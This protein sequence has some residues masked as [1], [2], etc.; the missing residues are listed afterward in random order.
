MP[1]S[2][3]SMM[4]P[5][6]K[7]RNG[8]RPSLPVPVSAPSSSRAP[9][10]VE[11]ALSMVRGG[12]SIFP[13]EANGKKPAIAGGFKAATKDEGRVKRWFN[14][15]ASL[16]IGIAT[17]EP[18]RFFALDA[19]GDAGRKS[20]RCLEA[21]NGSLP[22]TVTV[23]TPH[24]NHFYFRYPGYRVPCSA[25][26]IASGIDIRG[27][28]G[29]VVAPSSRTKD[30]QYRF[31]PGHGPRDV[32]IANA[33]PWLLDL[34]GKK[35][36][37]TTSLAVSKVL[38]PPPLTEKTKQYLTAAALGEFARLAKA[39]LHQRNDT[40]NLCA[41]KLGKLSVHGFL[42][43][44]VIIDNLVALAKKIGLNEAEILPTIHSG[45]SAGLKTPAQIPFLKGSEAPELE[46]I[47]DDSLTEKLARLGET[48]IDN[49]ARFVERVG[50][51]TLYSQ[52]KAWLIYDGQRYQANGHLQCIQV[53]ME[54]M[55]KVSDESPFLASESDKS[56]RK[57]F[58]EACQSKGHIDR[59]IELSKSQLLVKDASL[60]ADPWLLNTPSGTVNLREFQLQPHDPETC[61]PCARS[62]K[63][64][65]AQRAP[66]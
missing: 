3:T 14:G 5:I 56:Q 38:I 15:G 34:I 51:S 35:P 50:A 60:D 47:E 37:V 21:K 23:E 6:A 1:N 46:I 61:S 49:V 24:G 65:W 62:L 11:V 25:G 13:V 12:L 39:P 64:N 42:N 28:G 63:R 8:F 36:L 4:R 58:A 66:C 7:S 59:M 52:A 30:G 9:T 55:K 54:V 48:D 57:R 19:D 40:L 27:D 33:P 17:G 41:F 53:A 29:Y 18:S 31:R 16:N 22:R 44:K 26:R 20:L 43:H 2:K 45:F 10:K 32:G